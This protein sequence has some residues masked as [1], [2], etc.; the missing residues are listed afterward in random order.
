MP[1]LKK[2]DV[3]SESEVDKEDEEE[4]SFETTPDQEEGQDKSAANSDDEGDEEDYEDLSDLDDDQDSNSNDSE[5]GYSSNSSEGV[6]FENYNNTRVFSGVKKSSVMMMIN[7]AL[8][9]LHEI[10]NGTKKNYANYA[11]KDMPSLNDCSVVSVP[12]LH[13]SW[14]NP[15]ATNYGEKRFRFN[16]LQIH[17]FLN[18]VL[19]ANNFTLQKSDLKSI[20]KPYFSD[21]EVFF[22]AQAVANRRLLSIDGGLLSP[23]LNVQ[24]DKLL[25]DEHDSKFETCIYISKNKGLSNFFIFTTF[26]ET[27]TKFVPQECVKIDEDGSLNCTG[28][29]LTTFFRKIYNVAKVEVFSSLKESEIKKPYQLKTNPK[30]T[31]QLPKATSPQPKLTSILPKPTS[32]QGLLDKAAL[33]NETPPSSPKSLNRDEELSTPA[34]ASLKTATLKKNS[35]SSCAE[36][37]KISGDVIVPSSSVSSTRI[38]EA[39]P[40]PSKYPKRVRTQ[41]H[42]S[43]MIDPNMIRRKIKHET[44]TDKP[45]PKRILDRK[46]SKKIETKEISSYPNKRSPSKMSPNAR[47]P[48]KRSPKKLELPDNAHL[49]EWREKQLMINRNIF[50]LRYYGQRHGMTTERDNWTSP[51][52]FPPDDKRYPFF[53]LILMICTPKAGDTNVMKIMESVFVCYNIT[54]SWILEKSQSFLSELFSKIGRHQENA[55]V[56]QNMAKFLISNHNGEVPKS[57][58]ELKKIPGVGSK[59]AAVVMYEC[60]GMSEAIAMDSHVHSAFLALKWVKSKDPEVAR[61]EAEA[62]IPREYWGEMNFVYGGL[63]QLFRD[64]LKASYILSEATRMNKSPEAIKQIQEFVNT[65]NKR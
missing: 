41:V 48:N 49:K 51:I 10:K 1:T 14:H 40:S 5:E 44:N 22:F 45:T 34:T 21:N 50:F 11:I 7:K 55:R 4:E 63:G 64:R 3:E 9:N 6:E 61:L 23:I 13:T 15:L 17:E 31:S 19:G 62:W 18:K 47:S 30:P 37:P 57:F 42:D 32:A 58:E 25:K 56:L 33:T 39:S 53:C 52:P 54:P 28:D 65:K 60:F 43:T 27:G 29:F 38:S 46:R 36:S 12:D 20:F 26:Y 8:Q 2:M 35:S 24:Q 16:I 59:I